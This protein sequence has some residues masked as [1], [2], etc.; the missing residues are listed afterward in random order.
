MGVRERLRLIPLGADRNS[1]T[2]PP[3][4]DRS[5]DRSLAGSASETCNACCIWS[6]R[7]TNVVLSTQGS[8]KPKYGA[9]GRR[10]SLLT[11]RLAEGC[12][13]GHRP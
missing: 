12:G 5:R 13:N 10:I 9:P 6:S 2:T 8:S 1:P 11:D 3:P 7:E 4:H